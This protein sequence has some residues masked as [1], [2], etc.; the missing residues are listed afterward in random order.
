MPAPAQDVKWC[1]RP[2]NLP[3]SLRTALEMAFLIFFFVERHVLFL[4]ERKAISYLEPQLLEA[5]FILPRICGFEPGTSQGAWKFLP[6]PRTTL[7][8]S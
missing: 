1:H 7:S 6:V 2:L 4:S 5:D 3:V 8:G